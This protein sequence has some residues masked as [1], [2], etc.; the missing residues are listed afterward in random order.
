MRIFTNTPANSLIMDDAPPHRA[1]IFTARFQE[2]R[3]AYVSPDLNPIE[4]I[5]DPL[6]RDSMIQPS[7]DLAELHV[8]L[9]EEWNTFCGKIRSQLVGLLGSFSQV[10]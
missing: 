2:V 3:V 1:K 5:R 8:A 4:H 7:N 9:G 6:K 10:V